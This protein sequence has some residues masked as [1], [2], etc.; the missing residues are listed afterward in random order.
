MT[1]TLYT[2]PAC[3]RHNP[4]PDRDFGP[5]RIRA[6][7]AA[8][9][10]LEFGQLIWREASPITLEH[11]RLVHTQ[12]Y[13]DSVLAPIPSGEERAFDFETFA[14]RGTA[15]A[16]LHAAGLVMQATDDVIAGRAHNAFCVVSPGGHHAE[17]DKALGYCFFNHVAVA[18]VAAQKILGQSRMAV[19]D[20]D[21][22]HGNGTQSVFWN[23]RDRLFVSLHEENNLSGFAHE[24]GAW[25]NVL[26]INL[27][28][29]S[30]HTAFE[31]ALENQALPKIANFKPDILFVSAGFDM[32]KDDPLSGLCLETEDYARIG[33]RLKDFADV[34]CQGRLVAVL[35][36]GY[37]LDALAASVAAFVKGRM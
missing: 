10:T 14:T 2:H 8:L 4:G 13:I 5:A 29:G 18:A 11:L 30:D 16:A 35:E 17:A 20:I 31:Q 6:V 21:A 23:H 1:T 3:L 37:N 15:E 32:H 24:I 12:E 26:N 36:G 19:L 33:K 22:H 9:K 7:L 34:T 25:G 28:T 27:P